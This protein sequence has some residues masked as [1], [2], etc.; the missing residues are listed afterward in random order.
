MADNITFKS[1]FLNNTDEAFTIPA[2][3]KFDCHKVK[4]FEALIDGPELKEREIEGTAP[5]STTVGVAYCCRNWKTLPNA[6]GGCRR[7]F[8]PTGLTPGSCNFSNQQDGYGCFYP[9]E[10]DCVCTPNRR[11]DIRAALRRCTCDGAAFQEAVDNER[12]RNGW[13]VGGAAKPEKDKKSKKG[14]PAAVGDVGTAP[15]CTMRAALAQN[16]SQPHKH[17]YMPAGGGA[18]TEDT[19][20]A[21]T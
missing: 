9:E 3:L 16:S 18:D 4:G 10:F 19:D 2:N 20:T 15:A 17:A 11:T 1:K 7:G 13:P 6:G 12:K 5:G 14:A 21:A 8:D